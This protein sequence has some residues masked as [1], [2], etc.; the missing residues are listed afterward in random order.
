MISEPVPYQYLH[1]QQ[2]HPGSVSNTNSNSPNIRQVSSGQIPNRE[3]Q[4]QGDTAGIRPTSN[5]YHNSETF[6][7]QLLQLPLPAQQNQQA[8]PFTTGLPPPP[9]TMFNLGGNIH[10]ANPHQMPP[11][12]PPPPPLSL[13]QSQSQQQQYPMGGLPPTQNYSNNLMSDVSSTFQHFPSTMQL[14]GNPPSGLGQQ[15]SSNYASYYS[16]NPQISQFP[17]RDNSYVSTSSNTESSRFSMQNSNPSSGSASMY[18]SSASAGST[19]D[20]SNINN[21]SMINSSEG[22]SSGLPLLPVPQFVYNQSQPTASFTTSSSSVNPRSLNDQFSYSCNYNN[23]SNNNNTY[24]SLHLKPNPNSTPPTSS[25]DSPQYTDSQINSNKLLPPMSYPFQQHQSSLP[26]QPPASQLLPPQPQPQQQP[27][28]QPQPQPQQQPQP[29]PRTVATTTTVKPTRR[30]RV[31]MKPDR[32]TEFPCPHCRKVFEKS[33]NLKS[34]LKIHSDEK[35][36]SCKHCQRCFARNHDRKRHELL[37]ENVKKY[38]CG[39]TFNNVSTKPEISSSNGAELDIFTPLSSSSSANGNSPRWGCGK[40]FSRVDGLVRHYN[41][42][43]GFICV[44]PLLQHIK[45]M[46]SNNPAGTNNAVGLTG[47]GV[48]PTLWNDYQE[49]LANLGLQMIYGLIN[50]MDSYAALM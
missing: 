10:G 25:A 23:S 9:P 12:P 40:K 19:L 11:P 26:Y 41:T 44:K 31:T 16:H 30:R 20:N 27:Q 45:I 29:Q 5:S 22:P 17:N 35:P 33:Y 39:S 1:Q 15:F 50:R 13:P 3:S 32:P 28:P 36:F 42:E 46:Y 6:S 4:Y 18:L 8:A 47:Y 14:G 37:H 49:L 34:H 7:Q 24:N 38:T 43:M 48:D 2:Q 21:G